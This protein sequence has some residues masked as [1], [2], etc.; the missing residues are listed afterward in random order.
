M[1]FIEGSSS[2]KESING[3]NRLGP[4]PFA[5]EFNSSYL[6]MK[7]KGRRRS[8]KSSLLDQTLVAGI[9]NIYADESLFLA[10][11]L[12]TRESGQIKEFE[13][14]KLCKSLIKIL[15]TSIGEGGTTF[16][17]FRD[18]EGINGNYGGQ[19]LVYKRTD[20]P[21]KTCGTK[22]KRQKVSGRSTHWC[23]KCQN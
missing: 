11:I 5:K 23:P 22:I 9:G 21:C 16:S 4:E 18:L 6:K 17:D 20:K 3:L 12:P 19:A 13:L 14:E 2:P 10:G 7:L 1:W 8:I 15:R